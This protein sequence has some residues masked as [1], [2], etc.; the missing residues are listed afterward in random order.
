M[1]LYGRKYNFQTRKQLKKFLLQHLRI[2]QLR[3]K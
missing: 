3:G 1:R 2:K